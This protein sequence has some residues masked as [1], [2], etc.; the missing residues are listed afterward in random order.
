MIMMLTVITTM[1]TALRFRRTPMMY[2]QCLFSNTPGHG[3]QLDGCQSM[4]KTCMCILLDW[5]AKVS[6]I[7]CSQIVFD[8]A[9][10]Q[11]AAHDI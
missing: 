1:R 7:Q 6:K 4:C 2:F 9:T 5:K 10:K 11:Y 3:P 8:C